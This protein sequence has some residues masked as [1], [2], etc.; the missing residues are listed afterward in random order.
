[1]YIGDSLTD[2][3][4]FRTLTDG[5]TIR[6]GKSGASAAQYYF[7]SRSGVDRFLRRIAHA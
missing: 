7:K 6:V 3:D 4:A 5:I 2:E 1:M